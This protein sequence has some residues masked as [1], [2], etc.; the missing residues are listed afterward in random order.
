MTLTRNA[1]FAGGPAPARRAGAWRVAAITLSI[2][3]VLFGIV[4]FGGGIWLIALGGSWYYGLA[5]AGLIATALLVW[6]QRSAA[7]KLYLVV[8][9]LTIGWAFWE[10]GLDF[11]ALI[12][13]LVAPTVVLVLLLAVLP[14]LR[15]SK[16]QG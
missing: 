8:W 14:A 4:L 12:P 3:L 10:V 2:I 16:T 13:R 7:L 9:L 15:P 11:W 6:Q 5:G 1:A